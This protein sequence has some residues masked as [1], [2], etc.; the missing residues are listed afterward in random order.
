MTEA[1]LK[2]MTYA[3]F[4]QW[5]NNTKQC[6]RIRTERLTSWQDWFVANIKGYGSTSA[7]PQPPCSIWF[8]CDRDRLHDL[9][10]AIAH[11]KTSFKEY[12]K[13]YFDVPLVATID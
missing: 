11:A 1:Q 12:L 4:E 13:D 5:L 7:Y 6:D 10:G 3:E 8:R 9:S 2:A